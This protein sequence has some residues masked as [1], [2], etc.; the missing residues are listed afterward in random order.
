MS[1]D[2]EKAI[3][4]RLALIERD[5]EGFTNTARWIRGIAAFL[6]LQLGA[7]IWSYAQM[8]AKLDNINLTEIESNVTTALTVLGDHGTEFEGLRQQLNR[9]QNRADDLERRILEN[10]NRIDDKTID[11]FYRSDGDRLEIRIKRLEDH[12]ILHNNN[13]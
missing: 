8:N 10:R 1:E 3:E 9:T 11:R 13:Q 12:L 4:T 5:L 2:D 6:F 7:F